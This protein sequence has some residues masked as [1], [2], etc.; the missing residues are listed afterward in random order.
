M[1]RRKAQRI[2]CR[3]SQC[4]LR[5]PHCKK[6][7]AFRRTTAVIFDPASVQFRS[8]RANKFTRRRISP[9]SPL[10]H[11]PTTAALIVGRTDNPGSPGRAAANR[12]VQAPHPAP[13]HDASRSAPHEQDDR[14]I[15]Q[16]MG[17][18]T[19]ALNLGVAYFEHPRLASRV[20][21]HALGRA[22]L[23]KS[24]VCV[25]TIAFSFLIF[26][27][28]NATTCK[29]RADNCNRLGGGAACYEQSR[30]ASCAASK[31]YVAP[32]GRSWEASGSGKK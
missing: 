1:A 10:R 7:I 2:V 13:L 17:M 24:V 9:P 28:A 11:I 29:Q 20:E 21:T 19:E 23:K 6:R 3:F 26:P 5:Q 15:I 31:T 12:G 30:M 18:S 4:G 8:G 14:N 16:I 25:A 32:S 27:S 22:T